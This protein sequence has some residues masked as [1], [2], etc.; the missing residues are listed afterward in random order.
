MDN[1]PAAAQ[2]APFSTFESDATAASGHL[3][4]GTRL[5][6][7]AL[8]VG[9][10]LGQGG[11]GITYKGGDVHLR[12]F[13]A[14]KEYFPQGSLRRGA[15]VTPS[16]T[17]PAANFERDR[18]AFLEE[19]RV[20][21]RFNHPGIVHVFAVFEEN[22]TAY[23]VMEYLDGPTLEQLVHSHKTPLPEKTAV[24]HAV[25][26][27]RAL[28]EIHGAGLLHRD[29]KP[30]NIIVTGGTRAVLID[31]GTARQYMRQL[32]LIKAE[33]TAGFAPLE[34]YAQQS[35]PTPATDV[36][37]L[38]ATLY[39]L[40]TARTP[41]SATDRAADVPLPPVRDLNPEV[42]PGIAEAI[43]RAL[44]MNPA[45]RP[46][47]A[48][49]FVEE[50]LNPRAP[51]V[52][53]VAEPGAAA[54]AAPPA[55]AHSTGPLMALHQKLERHTLGVNTIAWSPDGA[56]LLSGGQDKML[57]TWNWRTRSTNGHLG[58]HEMGVLCCAYSPN[59]GWIVSGGLDA[60][61]RL[62][63]AGSRQPL[64]ILRGHLQPVRTVGFSPSERIMATGG[65]DAV[66]LWDLNSGQYLRRL[67]MPVRALAYSPNGAMMAMA[68][69]AGPVHL[70]NT[71]DWS[72]RH[73]LDAGPGGANALSWSGDGALLATGGH[74]HIG[75][76]WN[77]ASGELHA[78]MAG[79][80]RA[81]NCVALSPDGTLLA[82]G[83]DDDTVRLWASRTGEFQQRHSKHS[84]HVMAIAFSPDGHTLASASRDK[85][86]VFC[87]CSA[88]PG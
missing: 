55:V 61:V 34:Q 40:L 36:Y 59:G 3:K 48:Q 52:T 63:D 10:V 11:F 79:H 22:G 88:L 28:A 66:V 4:A 20:V 44:E 16:P 69:A 5:R 78:T 24:A 84:D 60:T 39:F 7:G 15:T 18:T 6:Q 32:Q 45:D 86:I 83:G 56:T 62:W 31:F 30:A 64:S 9:P 53:P 51:A 29:V 85:T 67:E 74:D 76:V 57:Y 75:R 65:D 49:A 13:V 23:M 77:C 2:A 14:I 8:A 87:R 37:A 27:G 17:F 58:G 43:R 50:L 25:Q 38:G 33:L 68:T 41:V 19:A 82:T 81:I 26:I 54:P 1:I 47:S 21:A 73:T 70:W 71:A 72:H 46:Q 12:R 35:R 80:S 42:S